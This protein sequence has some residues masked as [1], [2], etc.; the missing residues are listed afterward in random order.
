LKAKRIATRYAGAA[1]VCFILSVCGGKDLAAP[2]NG[3]FDEP[4]GLLDTR[5]DRSRPRHVSVHGNVMVCD[6]CGRQVSMP[7]EQGSSHKQT[8]TARVREHFITRDGWQQTEQGVFCP[9]H[10]VEA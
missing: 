5:V 6:N 1:R 4:P 2:P 9:D 7:M 10:M 8:L 3:S